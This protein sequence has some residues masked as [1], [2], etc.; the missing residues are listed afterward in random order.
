MQFLLLCFAFALASLQLDVEYLKDSLF[1]EERH[2]YKNQ[3]PNCIDSS[4]FGDRRLLRFAVQIHNTDEEEPVY[5]SV[6]PVI[7]Y[8]TTFVNGSIPVRC[9][10]D[11]VCNNPVFF[12]CHPLAISPHCSSRILAYEA[13]Q[14]I[15]ITNASST[16]PLIIGLQFEGQSYE[17]SVNLTAIP[18]PPLRAVAFPIVVLVV[19]NLIFILIP[20]AAYRLSVG[21][22]SKADKVQ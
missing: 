5:R 9:L 2:V 7:Y 22:A 12:T 10:R 20:F 6:Y 14:W 16:D 8:E 1:I 21:A 3:F 19:A 4:T 18:S 13:C 11:S 15:D 17:L